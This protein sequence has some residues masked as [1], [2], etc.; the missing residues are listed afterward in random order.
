M[1]E[2]GKTLSIQRKGRIQGREINVKGPLEIPGEER[3]EKAEALK[4]RIAGVLGEAAK[5]TRPTV[6]G[7]VRLTGLDDSVVPEEVADVLA[8]KGDG[9]PKE[10]KVGTIRPMNN[11]L[12][13]VWAQG[14]IEVMLKASSE[15]KLK[16]GWTVARIDLLKNR[17]SQCYRCWERGHIMAHRE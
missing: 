16:I 5:V 9:D 3:N 7:E 17:P 8:M 1:E 10:I 13:M 15:G 11:G 14:P 6:K 4:K 2:G 12:N